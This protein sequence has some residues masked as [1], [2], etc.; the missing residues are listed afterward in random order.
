MNTSDIKGSREGLE[1]QPVRSVCKGRGD[2]EIKGQLVITSALHLALEQ[3]LVALSRALIVLLSPS[4]EP[5]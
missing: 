3:K 2:G 4:T 5:V 1:I